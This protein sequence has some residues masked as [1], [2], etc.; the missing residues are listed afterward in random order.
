MVK[1]MKVNAEIEKN[2]TGDPVKDNKM[3]A[4][5]VRKALQEDDHY[6][7]PGSKSTLLNDD[8]H[9]DPITERYNIVVQRSLINGRGVFANKKFRTG[10]EVFSE[11]PFVAQ[12]EHPADKQPPHCS[13]CLKHLETVDAVMP[14]GVP[15]GVLERLD[16]AK[17]QLLGIKDME[18]VRGADGQ[19]YCSV[20]C[21]DEAWGEYQSL[22]AD[23]QI[24]EKIK[25][26][27]GTGANLT[28]F[29]VRLLARLE[30]GLREDA[31]LFD[32][33]L[34]RLC[35]RD[36]DQLEP[37]GESE[38]W[39]L[40][41]CRELFPRLATT[42]ILTPAGLQRIKSIVNHNTMEVSIPKPMLKVTTKSL[43][44]AESE[45]DDTPT[46]ESLREELKAR[47]APEDMIDQ[48]LNMHRIE[49]STPKPKTDLPTPA[50]EDWFALPSVN[51]EK[52]ITGSALYLMGS[53]L[54]HSC[55]PA[56]GLIPSGT[57]G[58]SFV[59]VNDIDVGEELSVSYIGDDNQLPGPTRRRL[60]L[61]KY[62]FYCNCPRCQED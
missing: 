14:P 37:L 52:K 30:S 29:V 6:T 55:A 18:P 21:K 4:A 45:E 7:V 40:T 26:T 2:K 17:A 1:A 16:E 10:D 54:N 25:A 28:L 13:Y 43:M 56:L 42:K 22:F 23:T 60:L 51:Y 19:A 39:L 8:P 41:A 58:A 24:L 27:A 32:D 44:A 61:E 3:A 12:A 59:A 9:Y 49:L 20:K 57:S 46:M 47:G 48:F 5:R 34:K 62:G 31:N 38:M 36:T 53:L 33:E 50:D 15:P 35:Y 11:L